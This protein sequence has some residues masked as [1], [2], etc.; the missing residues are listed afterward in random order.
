[1]VREAVLAPSAVG[2]KASWM[3]QLPPALIPVH[4]PSSIKSP[5]SAPASVMLE[6]F[7]CEVPILVRVTVCALLVE[8]TSCWPKLRLAVE[9][10]KVVCSNTAAG[11]KPVEFVDGTTRSSSPSPLKSATPKL[12]P[13]FPTKGSEIGLP[14]VPSPLPSDTLPTPMTSSLPSPLKSA[15]CTTLFEPLQMLDPNVPSPLPGITHRPVTPFSLV[16]K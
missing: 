5:G 1:M 6:T 3:V 9:I 13:P 10:L 15:S 8:P 16:P 2:L 7:R 14:N 12:G 4:L 11:L